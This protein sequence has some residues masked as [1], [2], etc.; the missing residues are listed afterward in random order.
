[1]TDS[2]RAG[3]G[4]EP[5]RKLQG[6]TA[7]SAR[8]E[9][10]RHDDALSPARA[11][12]ESAGQ[13]GGQRLGDGL[14]AGGPVVSFPDAPPAPPDDETPAGPPRV[15]RPQRGDEITEGRAGRVSRRE[16]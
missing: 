8:S 13:G 14:P 4:A 15:D 11:L 16:A 7:P 6:D 1:M 2:T 3:E 5:S 10:A 12:R 9:V